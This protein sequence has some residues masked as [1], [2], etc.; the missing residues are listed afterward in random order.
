MT[1]AQQIYVELK[2]SGD[3]P[4]LV[5]HADVLEA[6]RLGE[7]VVVAVYELVGTKTVTAHVELA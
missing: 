1:F 5:A 3:G 7:S 2:E 6:A 4:Y